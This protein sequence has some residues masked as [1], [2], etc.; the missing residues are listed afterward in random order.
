MVQRV[1]LGGCHC[2]AIAFRLRWDDE[3]DII[4]CNCSIC[5]KKGFLHLIVPEE[6]FELLN[7]G[8]SLVEYRFNTGVA[9]HKFC[10]QCGIHAFYSPRSHPDSVDVNLRCVEDVDVSSLN[11]VVFDGQNWEANISNIT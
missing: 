2:G 5:R 8:E 10:R 11:V 9:I 1:S 3:M 7:G 6:N 4:D